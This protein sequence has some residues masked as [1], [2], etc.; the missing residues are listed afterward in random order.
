MY[1]TSCTHIWKAEHSDSQLTTC[2]CGAFCTRHAAAR[3]QEAARLT[4]TDEQVQLSTYGNHIGDGLK[5]LYTF[6]TTRLKGKLVSSCTTP[7]IPQIWLSWCSYG[8][9]SSH[10]YAIM[11]SFV[12]HYAAGAIGGVHLLPV[13]PSS[14]DGGFAPITY[15][16]CHAL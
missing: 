5:D 4:C 15:K 7:P 6:L 14:G 2:T 12:T 10:H 11:V 1:W 16:V 13:Y 9:S 3:S 8:L